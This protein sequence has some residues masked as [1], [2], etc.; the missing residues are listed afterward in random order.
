[1]VTKEHLELMELMIENH[2][3]KHV[4]SNNISKSVFEDTRYRTYIF[5]CNDQ[6][7][8]YCIIR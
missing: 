5:V 6:P 3:F 8:G 7:I 1:M 2:P 4:I